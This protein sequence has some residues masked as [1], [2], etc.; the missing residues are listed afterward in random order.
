MEEEH[1]VCEHISVSRKQTWDECQKKYEF[2]YH[3]KMASPE[4]MQPY[5]TYGKYIHKIAEV[6]TEGKGKRAIEAIAKDVLEGKIEVEKGK[7]N[8]PLD[9]DYKKKLP[10]H[11]RNLKTLTDKI[12]YDGQLEWPFRFDLDPPNNLCAVGFIDRLIVRGDKYFVLDYKTTKKGYWRK[13]SN[14]IRQDLQLRFYARVVQKEFGAKAENIKGALYYLEGGD[15]VAT[16]FTEDSILSAE[17]E[18]LEAYKKI[19]STKPEDVWARTGE[20][21]RRCDYRSVC[22]A[23]SLT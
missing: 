8:L 18:L 19:L 1:L 7:P 6:Y 22:P 10:S 14:T 21:C 4:P 17:A 16:N 9:P 5:F 20:H 13:N 3:L 23:R 11:I 2:R 15:L 12:G